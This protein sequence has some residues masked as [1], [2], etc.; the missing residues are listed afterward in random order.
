[1]STYLPLP[2]SVHP[3]LDGRNY[4]VIATIEPSG[5]PQLSVVWAKRDGDDVLFSTTASRRKSLNLARDPRATIL[6]YALDDPNHYV[7][8]RG[9]TEIVDDPDGELIEELSLKYDGRP[10]NDSTAG[11][12]IVRIHPT[13]VVDGA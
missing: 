2:P 6:V 8:V 5:Q 11:R 12:I 9:E 1:M 3:L 13:K 7:E 10:W 4:A